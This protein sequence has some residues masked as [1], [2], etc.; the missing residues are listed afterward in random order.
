M[1]KEKYEQG[2]MAD[3]RYYEKMLSNSVRDTSRIYNLIII[4]ST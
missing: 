3:H 1:E 4:A 2:K